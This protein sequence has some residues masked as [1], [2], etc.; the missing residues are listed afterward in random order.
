MN[1][2][3]HSFLWVCL[4]AVLLI[5]PTPDLHAQSTES[6]TIVILVRHAE[7]ADYDTDDPALTDEGLKRVRKLTDMLD[8]MQPDLIYSTD[9][10]R[11][12]LTVRPVALKH[13]LEIRTYNPGELETFLSG[14][15]DEHSGKT[16][17]ISGHSNT[18]PET[19]N[20]LLGREHFQHNFDESD[21]GNLLFITSSG[22]GSGKLIHLRY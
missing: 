4:L 15:M 11:T 3:H 21:Y 10:K 9:Y 2:S 19:A 8:R 7:K 20:L 18:I 5:T 17:V 6:E 12:R 13:G 16:I 1:T 22:Y 14:L